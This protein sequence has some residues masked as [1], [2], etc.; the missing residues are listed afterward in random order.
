MERPNN[1]MWGN[2]QT[3][4][5]SDVSS[6]VHWN[7][8]TQDHVLW[9]LEKEYQNGRENVHAAKG[10]CVFKIK[11]GCIIGRIEKLTL[12]SQIF[13]VF[14]LLFKTNLHKNHASQQ[15]CNKT[16]GFTSFI[17]SK[18]LLQKTCLSFRHA[19][20]KLLMHIYI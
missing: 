16:T 3:K 9:R 15:K 11:H 10:L 12:K 14:C 20:L 8:L 1:C 5:I 18:S 19:A 2:N 7:C 13:N 6:T 17:T 4:R